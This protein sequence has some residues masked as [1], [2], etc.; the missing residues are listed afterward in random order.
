MKANC[1]LIL[2]TNDDGVTSPGLRAAAL[3]LEPLGDLLIAGPAV[4][5]SGAGRSMPPASEG[6][7]IAQK[8]RLNQHE[9]EGY[10]IEGSPAQVVLHAALELAPRRPDLVVSGINYGENVGSGITASGTV[11]AAL[12]GADFGIPAL[13]FSLQTALEYYLIPSESVSFGVAMHFLALFARQV[14]TAG[15]PA[16]AD[17]LKIDV[18]QSATVE[19]PWRWTRMSRQRYFVPVK[20]H[21][22][23]PGDPGPMGFEIKIDPEMLEPDSD[24]QAVA[25]DGVVSVT[26]LTLD[27]TAR[28][29]PG[30]LQRW[31]DQV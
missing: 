5:H 26:P 19:T 20:P 22:R 13:A 14:L 4:Q 23:R 1:P 30:L 7:I 28:V 31:M 8:I 11:G 3:A 2:V 21:R 12:E 24:I 18:P 6:R 10:G 16:G 15:L 9:V 25:I 17:L 27:M 29:E